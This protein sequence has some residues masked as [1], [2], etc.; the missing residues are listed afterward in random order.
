MAM[1]KLALQLA[2][3]VLQSIEA[4]LYISMRIIIDK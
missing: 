2:E 1:T 3:L 4:Y